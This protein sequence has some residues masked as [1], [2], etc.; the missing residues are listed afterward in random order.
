MGGF[1]RTTQRAAGERKRNSECWQLRFSFQK[2]S[3]VHTNLPF[4]QAHAR[5]YL[6]TAGGTQNSRLLSPFWLAATLGLGRRSL[7]PSELLVCKLVSGEERSLIW[8][9]NYHYQYVDLIHRSL[10]HSASRSYTVLLYW[11]TYLIIS[12]EITE[13]VHLLP[14]DP[15]IRLEYI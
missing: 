12:T 7:E 5:F 8:F 14:L 10:P 13:G 6:H 11:P 9:I 2:K 3:L 4:L 1:G 15:L